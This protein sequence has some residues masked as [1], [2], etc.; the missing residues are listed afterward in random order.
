[1]AIHPPLRLSNSLL[2]K[3]LGL[4]R[5]WIKWEGLLPLKGY[6]EGYAAIWGTTAWLDIHTPGS[7]QDDVRQP[8]QRLHETSVPF[9]SRFLIQIP[10]CLRPN[11]PSQS[12]VYETYPDINPLVNSSMVT[13]HPTKGLFWWEKALYALLWENLRGRGGRNAQREQSYF[14]KAMHVRE[15]ELDLGSLCLKSKK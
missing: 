8:R 2:Y 12:R 11:Y 14:S 5:A 9:V 4:G 10:S 3:V 13:H 7:M 6:S 1:M 15:P